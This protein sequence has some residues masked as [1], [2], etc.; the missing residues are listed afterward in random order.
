MGELSSSAN[1]PVGGWHWWMDVLCKLERRMTLA[2]HGLRLDDV[3][4]GMGQRSEPAN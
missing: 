3:K 4:P 1:A 2:G